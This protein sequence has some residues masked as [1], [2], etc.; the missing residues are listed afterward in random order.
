[1]DGIQRWETGLN[2][3]SKEKDVS[4]S[5]TPTVNSGEKVLSGLEVEALLRVGSEHLFLLFT[6]SRLILA[7]Q[8]KSGL[9]TVPLY[10]LLGKMSEGLKRGR[11]KTGLL[12][13]MVDTEPSQILSLHPENF[14][15]EYSRLVSLRIEEVGRMRRAKII[16]VT[17]DQK[18]E[19]YASPIAVEGVRKDVKLL[20]K[21]KAEYGRLNG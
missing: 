3:E 10:G 18:M 21:E 19:L 17:P 9:G 7:H 5:K 13:K 14:A 8:T 15:V 20:L 6:R 11:A 4:P 1:M 2:A 16:L 12:Q